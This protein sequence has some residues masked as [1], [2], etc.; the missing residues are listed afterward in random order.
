MNTYKLS[1]IEIERI[2]VYGFSLCTEDSTLPL[3][4]APRGKLVTDMERY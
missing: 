3:D 4:N 1:Q 2:R